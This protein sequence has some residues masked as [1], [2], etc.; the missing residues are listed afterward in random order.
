MKL[1]IQFIKSLCSAG[2]KYSRPKPQKILIFDKK[3]LSAIKFLLRKKNFSILCVRGEELNWYVIFN[4]LFNLKKLNLT[5]YIESYVRFVNPSH[6]I[7]HS[8]NHKF[9]TLKKIFP[10]IKII[11]IQSE[12]IHDFEYKNFKK[13]YKCDHSFVWGKTDK[14][15]FQKHTMSKPELIGSINS[16]KF[17]NMTVKM[18]NEKL[19][20]ISQ[21]RVGSA[22]SNTF[23]LNTGKKV[24][25]S[26][27]Y[28]PDLL[29]IS[30]LSKYCKIN[31]KK[32]FIL[33]SSREKNKIR[34]E[35]SFYK[36]NLTD[37]NYKFISSTDKNYGYKVTSKFDKI[38]FINS[39]L[40]FECLAKNKKC[41]FFHIRNKFLKFNY[42]KLPFKTRGIL[43]TDSLKEEDIFKKVDA[44]FKINSKII[45]K[46]YQKY[47]SKIIYYDKNNLFLKNKI[48]NILYEKNNIYN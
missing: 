36:K 30:I 40:G 16:N 13:S 42:N 45:D 26:L 21:F 10:K 44:L 47:F 5:N 15:Q 2:F 39:T 14:I 23:T 11:Y 31:K 48:N 24:N 37:H 7:N 34:I 8:I 20:F 12:L 27:Y 41:V 18:S 1:L 46:Y 9:F 35:Q 19:L 29:I 38:A 6:I 28:K 25:H 32:L 43:W 22:R 33:A 17:N 3:G 4:L